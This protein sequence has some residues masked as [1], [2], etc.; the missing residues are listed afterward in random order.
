MVKLTLQTMRTLLAGL[1]LLLLSGAPVLAQDT[2]NPAAGEPDSE[3]TEAAP[4]ATEERAEEPTTAPG[5]A[6]P[7][8]APPT[9]LEVLVRDYGLDASK[10]S[11]SELR[12]RSEKRAQMSTALEQR[13]AKAR[14]EADSARMVATAVEDQLS[15]E[16]PEP[17]VRALVPPLVPRL[18][19]AARAESAAVALTDG[20][21]REAKIASLLQRAAESAEQ[22]AARAEESTETEAIS[23]SLRE[24]GEA[25][26]AAIEALRL[27]REREE[28][29][30]NQT[31][32]ELLARETRLAE[33]VLAMTRQSSEQLRALE[34][35]TDAEVKAFADAKAKILASIDQ[36]PDAPTDS[37]RV[38]LVDPV[39]RELVDL[40]RAARERLEGARDRLDVADENVEIAAADVAKAQEEVAREQAR[41]D[42]LEASVGRQRIAVARAQ[43][44]LAEQK[45]VAATHLQQAGVR[46][47]REFQERVEFF[48]DQIEALLPLASSQQRA[49][50]YEFTDANIRDAKNALEEGVRRVYDGALDRFEQFRALSFTSIELW[51]WIGELVFRLGFLIFLMWL[52]PVIHTQIQRLTQAMFRRRFFRMRPRATVKLAELL[53]AL[54]RPLLAYVGIYVILDYVRRDFSEVEVVM[55]AVNGVFLYW[56]L[57]EVMSVLLLPRWFRREQGK[58]SATELG[59]VEEARGA[60]VADVVGMDVAVARKLL[61]SVKVVTAFWILGDYVPK[62]VIE[63]S[64]HSIVSWTI[65]TLAVAGIAVVVLWAL[66]TWKADIARIFERLAKD[67]LPR[68]VEWVNTYKDR[69]YGIFFIAGASVYVIVMEASRLGRRYAKGTEAFKR[70]STFAFRKKIELQ[71]REREESVM[72]D[73]DVAGLPAEYLALFEP[74]PLPPDSPLYIER[75]KHEPA[76]RAR[77]EQWKTDPGQGSVALVGEAGVGKTTMMHHLE[78]ALAEDEMP[79]V[80]RTITEKRHRKAEVLEFLGE[81]FELKKKP[82]D[83]AHVI[84]LIRELEPQIVMLD[85]CH[86]FF[87]RQIGGFDGLEMLLDVVNLTDDRHFYIL[88]FN[89]FAWSYVNRVSAR[90]HYFG[91]VEHLQGWSEDEIQE[92]V[93]RRTGQ[94]EFTVSFQD[95][96]IQHDD[97]MNDGTEYFYEVVKTARGYFRYLHEFTN[98]NPSLSLIFWLRSLRPSGAHTLQVS[99]FRRPA[100]SAL[101]AVSDNHWFVLTALAQHGEL[102]ASEVAEVINTDEGFCHLALNFFEEKGIVVFDDDTERARLAPLFFRH[103]LKSLANINYLYR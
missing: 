101:D 9:P 10:A 95:L 16:L 63:F 39:F 100:T 71:A 74:E 79:V 22:A 35:D 70:L 64:G 24:Q 3:V 26:Q 14:V 46:R 102:R 52:K 54:T 72:P 65:N 68:A 59:T 93:E 45:L 82:R 7:E 28:K 1:V 48:T 86:H 5:Q 29:E 96:V 15:E 75:E 67:R 56:I 44:N 83:K 49:A 2:P 20:A 42:Q 61:R 33:E 25:E 57:V 60:E 76:I 90:Q 38:A 80:W 77:I 58:S 92:L 34:E 88:S 8:P 50:F 103:V 37:Q 41:S 53:N 6:E 11:P 98:G 17:A 12:T 85:D 66:H 94:T 23:E 84:E 97:D 36:I 78:R 91:A 55:W 62:L 18:V 73:A 31:V 32:K 19:T 43:L 40:R 30:R 13:A 87:V 47:V 99:L 89:V 51:G 4:T 81:L 27:A 21:G 69:W